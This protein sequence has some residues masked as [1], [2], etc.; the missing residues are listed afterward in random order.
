MDMPAFFIKGF[1]IGLSV[2][3]PVGP[4]GFLCIQR[5]L[6]GGMRFGFVSGLGAAAADAAYGAVAGFGL[7]AIS[8]FLVAQAGWARGIGGLFLLYLA[9]RIFTTPPADKGNGRAA[10]GLLAAFT[11]VFALTLTN[12]TTI[13]SFAAIFAGLGLVETAGDFGLAIVLVSGVFVGS[14]AWWLFLSG[15][16]EVLHRRVGPTFLVW[17]NRVSALVIGGFGVWALAGLIV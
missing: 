3:A 7:S 2:A 14:A 16:S 13:L 5:T 17:V 9:V 11:S 10:G 1:L 12:P 4:I 6:N 15:V 8:A